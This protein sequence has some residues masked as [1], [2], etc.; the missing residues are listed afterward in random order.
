MAALIRFASET[1]HKRWIAVALETIRAA[2]DPDLPA[3]VYAEERH[4]A[5]EHRLLPPALKE[6]VNPK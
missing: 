4:A 3:K 1:Q 5:T 2:K 6:L